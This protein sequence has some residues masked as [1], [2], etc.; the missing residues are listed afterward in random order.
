[1]GRTITEQREG[2]EQIEFLR[3]FLAAERIAIR[4]STDPIVQD[5]MDLLD[6]AKVI[7]L[8]H[9]DTISGVLYLESVGLLNRLGRAQEILNAE[10]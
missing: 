4:K 6:K 9:P 5:F 2:L 1:V 10:C 7:R 3:L 8:D